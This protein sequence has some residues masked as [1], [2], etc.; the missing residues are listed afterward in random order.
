MRLWSIHPKYLDQKGLVALWR[1]GL[2]AQKVLMGQTQGYKFHP[3]L[4][5][6][7]KTKDSI[8]AVGTYLVEIMKEAE[9]RGYRFDES[10]IVKS[11]NC[12][13]IDVQAGQIEYE[14]NHLLKK[15]KA[16][17]SNV[18]DMNRGVVDKEAHPLFR[19][20]SGGI[21]DWERPGVK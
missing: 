13:K 8:L 4:M 12:S 7:R 15:L 3:Q 1:E 19:I 2:L 14:W 21:E 9:R 11:G 6:F 17:S 18:Y 10:K 16:R 20:V 5:R